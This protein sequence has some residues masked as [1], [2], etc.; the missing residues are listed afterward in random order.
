MFWD[1]VDIMVRKIILTGVIGCIDMRAS[2]EEVVRLITAGVI[3]FLYCI[4]LATSRPS[5]KRGDDHYLAVIS[6]ILLKHA[7]SQ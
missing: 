6:N 1:I 5:Y 7:A 2:T 3:S 4:L